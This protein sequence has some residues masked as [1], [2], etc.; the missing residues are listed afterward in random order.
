[1]CFSAAASY[2]ASAVL[3]LCGIAAIS[4]AKSRMRMFAAIPLIFSAQQ[5]LEGV[6]W[7]ALSRGESALIS[8]YA[9]LVFVFLIWPLWMPLA[10]RSISTTKR[11]LTLLNIPLAAGGFVAIFALVC[12]AYTTPLAAITCNS[13]RYFT[14]LPPYAWKI[15]TVAYL[16]ATIT[17]FFIVQQRYLWLMGSALS[18]SYILSFIFYH[19]TLLSIWCFLAALL[20]ILIL[21]LVW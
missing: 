12:A 15:G 3:L 20:S 14:D 6:T 17:P 19:Q 13:I 4:K 8:T 18:V 16:I 2:T 7:Q 1:M 5:F 10:A 11:E 21:F 9:Y